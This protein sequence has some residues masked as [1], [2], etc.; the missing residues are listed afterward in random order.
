M[1]NKNAKRFKESIKI[2]RQM[3][4]RLTYQTKNLI[5]ILDK[6]RLEWYLFHDK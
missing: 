5:E 4:D 1:V 3:Q 6:I 2:D